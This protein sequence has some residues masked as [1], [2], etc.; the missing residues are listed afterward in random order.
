GRT[1]LEFTGDRDKVNQT[2]LQIRPN[3]SSVRGVQCPDISYYMADLIR[4][5]NDQQ[6]MDVAVADTISC[7]NLDGPAVATAKPMVEAAVSRILQEGQYNNKV[8]FSLLKNVVRRL[9]SMPGS[10]GIILLSG[11]FLVSVDERSEVSD[12]MERAIRSTVTISA[13][14]ARG[15]WVVT[16]GGDVS[17]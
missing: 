14:D 10:R 1:M 2:L 5:Y 12:L 16:P 13:V 4:N 8:T 9:S 7:A 15:L 3:T 6:A 17:Q 11:G